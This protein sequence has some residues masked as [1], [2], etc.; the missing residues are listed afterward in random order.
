MTAATVTVSAIVPLFNGRRYVVEAVTSILG[1]SRVPDE[2]IVVDDGSTDGGAELVRGLPYVRVVRQEHAGQGVALNCGVGLSSGAFLAFLDADDRWVPDKTERQLDAFGADPRLDLVFGDAR[3][4]V[5]TADGTG[6]ASVA[7][8]RQVLPARLPSAIMVRRSAFERVGPFREDRS[9]GGVIDWA[10]R[11]ADSGLALRRLDRVVY[12][13]RIH[14]LNTG[15]LRF[16]ER[17]EYARVLKD[18]ID[19]RRRTRSNHG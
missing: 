15:V 13:R 4:F 10:T 9:L 6:S 14:A 11:A 7:G 17:G 2:I 12:E 5:E 19:R 16:H 18:V 1:Q 3:Q 8:P